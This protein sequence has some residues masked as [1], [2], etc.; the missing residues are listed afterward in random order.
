VATRGN[1][2]SHEVRQKLSYISTERKRPKTTLDNSAKKVHKRAH[3]L[4]ISVS[5]IMAI[6]VI[7]TRT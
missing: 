4:K 1:T 2:I 5:T 3:L 7:R 6:E